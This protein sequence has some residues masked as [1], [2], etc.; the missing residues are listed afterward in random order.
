MGK[1]LDS[2]LAQTYS[3]FE[4]IVIDDGSTDNT[5]R[6][7]DC[8]YRNDTRVKYFRKPNGGVSSSRNT[9]IERSAGKYIAFCDSDDVW[10]S[11]KLAM[12]VAV[13]EKFPEVGLV[14][15]DVTAV[16]AEGNTLFERYTRI[17]YPT[18]GRFAMGEIF[19]QCARLSEV[20]S[21][22]PIDADVY[23][24][25]V[26]TPMVVGCIIH[27]P[28]VIVSRERIDQIGVFDESMN[29]CEDYDFDLRACCAGQAAFIDLMSIDYRVGSPDQL[30][31]Q[32]LMVD[33]ARHF[34]TT[35]LQTIKDHRDRIALSEA[36]LNEVIA[37]RYSW[38]AREEFDSA[39]YRAARR[40]YIRSLR[41][42]FLQPNVL[43]LTVTLM[44][45]P[46]AVAY[47]R[48]QYRQLKTK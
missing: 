33:Q 45:P 6:L 8:Q 41:Y 42:Q 9:G 40:A 32:E 5:K 21:T 11:H 44:L 34:L 26:F 27:I 13:L 22:L 17:A 35:L 25:D 24:G 2:V 38:L 36:E 46:V 20:D 18:W 31:R 1:T 39:N 12:Q 19:D 16:N 10:H 30:T 3:N 29:V 23:I 15:T 43:L 47:L 14:W 48:R 4:I 7:I 28:T 37:K